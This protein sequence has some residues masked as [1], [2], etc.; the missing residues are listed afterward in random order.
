MDCREII[1]LIPAYLDGELGLQEGRSVKDHLD[2]CPACRKELEA[3][4]RSWAVLSEADEISPQPG[5]VGRFWAKLALEQPWYGKVL[6]KLTVAGARRAFRQFAP[7]LLTI[8]VVTIVVGF[9]ARRYLHIQTTNQMLIS[10]SAEDFDMVRNIELVEN[11]DPI[12]E[13][14]ILADLDIM[15]HLD[16]WET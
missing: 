5:Y 12:E 16:L 1:K 11:L 15:E 2:G 6:Q 14:D 8:C 10:M 9:A 4:E 3:F 7:T 13:I